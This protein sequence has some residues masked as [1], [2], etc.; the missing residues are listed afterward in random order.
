MYPITE[1][2]FS[3]TVQCKRIS[4]FTSVWFWIASIASVYSL[5][6]YQKDIS[7][8]YGFLKNKTCY[9]DYYYDSF[10]ELITLLSKSLSICG[11]T[12]AWLR[13]AFFNLNIILG[14]AEYLKWVRYS[15]VYVKHYHVISFRNYNTPWWE[16][17]AARLFSFI[18]G[19]VNPILLR[20]LRLNCNNL[21]RLRLEKRKICNSNTTDRTICDPPPLCK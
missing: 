12:N 5:W 20:P 19:F 6:D 1:Y 9:H 11:R 17:V 21:S 8:I 14:D 15:T 4:L 3:Y 7:I 16:E 18:Q 10:P 2:Y 13:Y